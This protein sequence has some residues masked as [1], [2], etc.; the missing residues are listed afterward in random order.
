MSQEFF[1]DRSF[2]FVSFSSEDAENPL[3]YSIYTAYNFNMNQV[4]SKIL[5]PIFNI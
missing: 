1:E 4:K 2:S 3:N 5:I